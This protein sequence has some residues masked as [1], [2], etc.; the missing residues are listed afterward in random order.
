MNCETKAHASRA[1][2]KRLA[3]CAALEV[4]Q[5]LTGLAWSVFR[6]QTH[7]HWFRCSGARLAPRRN[8]ASRGLAGRHQTG[9]LDLRKAQA[10]LR[11]VVQKRKIANQIR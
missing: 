8:V 5:W 11:R 3:V 6:Q 1:P 7:V 10:H 9:G 4:R 2:V